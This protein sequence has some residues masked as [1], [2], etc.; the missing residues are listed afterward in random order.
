M[1]KTLLIILAAI[2]SISS[3]KAQKSNNNKGQKIGETT[4]AFKT[5]KAVI[6][7]ANPDNFKSLSIIATNAPVHIDNITV[8]YETGDPEVI[9]IRY[10]FRTGIASRA[11]DLQNSQLKIK[12]VDLAYKAVSN[13]TDSTAHIEIW[14]LK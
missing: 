1:K 14:G 10:D 5:E 3:L 13:R 6:T 9:P 12:E 7:I 4:V 8:V 11:I 2:I